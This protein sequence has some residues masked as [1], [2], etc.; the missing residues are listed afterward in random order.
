MCTVTVVPSP[1]GSALRVLMNRD[2]RRLRPVAHPPT[3]HQTDSGRAVWSMDP[4]SGGTWMAATDKGLTLAVVNIDGQ[5]RSPGLLSRGA[6]IPLFAGARALD[7]V[8]D[9]WARLDASSFAPFRLLA[10]A[11]DAMVVCTARQRTPEVAPVTG[12]RVFASSSLGDAQVEPLRGELLTRMLRME[13]DHWSAQTR[14][15][16]HAWPD[17]RHLSV[18]MT[19]V[20]ACTVSQ[21]EVIVTAHS[22]S[23]AYR[24]VADGWPLAETR[25]VLPVDVAA[26]LAA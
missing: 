3:L 2:E 12:P 9:E 5:R 16:R 10:I 7:D 13:A 20:D 15:H 4:V 1:D 21:T 11:R 8:L 22:V 25:R 18:M 14:F 24:P 23:L 19:R 6:I 26:S 17:R